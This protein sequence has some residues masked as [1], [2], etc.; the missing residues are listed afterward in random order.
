[1]FEL[2][3]TIW[4]T[5]EMELIFKE[6]ANQFEAPYYLFAYHTEKHFENLDG[7]FETIITNFPEM[8][9]NRYWARHYYEDD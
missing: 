7:G 2:E 9:M 8:W 5:K 3:E 6:V 4:P 1:M